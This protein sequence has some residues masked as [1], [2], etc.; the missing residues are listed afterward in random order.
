MVLRYQGTSVQLDVPGAS[1]VKG[2]GTPARLLV[3]SWRLPARFSLRAVP[4]A[5]PVVSRAAEVQNAAPFALL[6]GPI[7]AYEASGLV[8][9]LQ[10]P[11]VA[12]GERFELSFGLEERLRLR[13][14]VLDESVHKDG[15][16]GNARRLD[17]AYRFELQSLMNEPA[18]V[19]LVDHLPVSEVADVG[20][21]LD[22]A[23]GVAREVSEDGL[24]TFAVHL[25]PFSSA[26]R[27]LS[28]HV[29]VPSGF[30]LGR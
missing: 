27:D 7:D 11:R 2:D 18:E 4:R 12:E 28:F 25:E 14:R 8:A 1:E 5:A 24:V 13:R 30:A 19:Q 15:L 6:P 16:F 21:E 23:P 20:V 17:F 3:G 29:K 22:D 26:R 9:R 10:L